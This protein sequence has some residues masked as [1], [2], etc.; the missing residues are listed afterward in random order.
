VTDRDPAGGPATAP[1]GVFVG[2]ATLDLVL[3]VEHVPAPDEKVV[4]VS[5]LVAAGGPAANA[6]VAFAWA[7]GRPRLLTVLGV[8]PLAAAALRDLRE[9]GVAVTDAAPARDEPPPAAAILVT[10]GTGARAVVS[11]V[12]RAP[13][14]SPA[15][16][17]PRIVDELLDGT[18]VVV[19]DGHHVGLAEPLLRAARAAGVPTL[20]DAGTWRPSFTRLLP[21]ADVVVASA[22]FR[23]PAAGPGPS[24]VLEDLLGRG[25]VFAATT[26][27]A[28][29]IHWRDATGK[30]GTIEIPPVAVVDTLGAGD[31][32]HGVLA[33]RL[34]GAADPD[35]RDVEM[36][37]EALAAAARV[38][39]AA[40]AF[41]GTRVWL[42]APIERPGRG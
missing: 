16:V 2:L 29:P 26:A 33:A 14:G 6:A 38:A 19:A 42:A 3:G 27:G 30:C 12:D 24:G 39:T 22:A 13:A 20:L 32:L 8:H 7:G 4:A 11:H 15:A 9:H 25:V 10:A 35:R 1:I 31:V 23:P 34:A 40:C 41:P 28:A 21:L 36:L 18:R 37:A 5:Q 17:E